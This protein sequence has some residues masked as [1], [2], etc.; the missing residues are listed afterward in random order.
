[1]VLNPRFWL[2]NKT[3]C[4]RIQIFQWSSTGT[5][6]AAQGLIWVSDG[7]S[8]WGHTF[9]PITD[10]ALFVKTMTSHGED[11]NPHRWK[12]GW[13]VIKR[14]A[15]VIKEVGEFQRCR[16][17]DDRKGQND[18]E[19][20]KVT[21]RLSLIQTNV[22]QWHHMGVISF[23]KEL[24]NHDVTPY[25]HSALPNSNHTPWNPTYVQ[26]FFFFWYDKSRPCFR[27]GKKIAD[28][29]ILFHPETEFQ[30]SPSSVE[31]ITMQRCCVN[32]QKR[33]LFFCNPSALLYL[34]WT[35]WKFG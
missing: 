25:P 9:N 20:R 27:K 34:M 22:C 18:D 11:R 10:P 7:F 16:I 30:P 12:D 15:W 2:I 3:H 8:P 31:N 21:S 32:I 19:L 14:S 29:F 28:D 23:N 6:S 26:D 13:R 4:Q 35:W 24:L 33:S 1:M 5:P 17:S